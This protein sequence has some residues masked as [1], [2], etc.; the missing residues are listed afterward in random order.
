MAKNDL[1]TSYEEYLYR[2]KRMRSTIGS[3]DWSVFI[4]SMN[5][6]FTYKVGYIPPGFAN[7]PDLISNVFFDTP[8]LWWLLLRVNNL[9]DPFESLNLGDRVRIPVNEL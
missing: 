4:K 1:E 3:R 8:S 5:D 6:V 7:R 9:E 2:G